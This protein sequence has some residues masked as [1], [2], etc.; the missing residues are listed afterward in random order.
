MLDLHAEGPGEMALPSEIKLDGGGSE[1]E[2]GA[3]SDLSVGEGG[4]GSGRDF[5]AE[6]GEENR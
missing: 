1:F 3:A 6:V 2:R 5:R 4:T